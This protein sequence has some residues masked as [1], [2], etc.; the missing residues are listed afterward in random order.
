MAP[1][2][3][4]VEYDDMS[5]TLDQIKAPV[6]SELEDFEAHFREAL[7]SDV[8][9]L[10]KITYYIVRRKGK[11]IRPIF[12]FLSARMFGECKEQ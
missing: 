4:G 6:A 10:D 1:T 7:K 12:V 3:F 2:S 5:R 11:Q 8:S 9:L